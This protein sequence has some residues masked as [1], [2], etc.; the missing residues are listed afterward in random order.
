MQQFEAFYSAK[1][2]G[3]RL[4]WAHSLERCVVRHCAVVVLVQGGYDRPLHK[5]L[6]DALYRR[7]VVAQWTCCPCSA[8]CSIG[9][10]LPM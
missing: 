3:R 2:Q 8:L 7:E 9:G 10:R 5:W 1:Y 4:M 6:M